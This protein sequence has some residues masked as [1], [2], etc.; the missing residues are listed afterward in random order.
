MGE[1]AA[2]IRYK[3]FRMGEFSEDRSQVE[4]LSADQF[5]AVQYVYRYGEFQEGMFLMGW[6]NGLSG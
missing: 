5:M 1:I 6:M 4:Y 3:K 2:V